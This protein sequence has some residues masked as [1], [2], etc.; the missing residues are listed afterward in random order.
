MVRKFELIPLCG[1]RF[2]SDSFRI[3]RIT[4]KNN[5]KKNM[6]FALALL[7]SAVSNLPFVRSSNVCLLTYLLADNDLE[8]WIR[9]DLE[10]LVSSELIQTPSLTSWIYFDH[11]N[12]GTNEDI[13]D[14]LPFVYNKDGS[15]RTGEKPEGSFYF[16]QD[17][18]LGKLVIEEDLGE[19]NSDSPETVKNFVNTALADCI[20]RGSEEYMIVFGSH[21]GGIV[22]FGGDE[23][24]RRRQ[25]ELLQTNAQITG[26][27]RSSLDA[28]LGPGSKFDVVGFDACLMQA[29]GT[30]DDYKS[31]TKYLLASEDLEPGHGWWYQDVPQSAGG[32]ALDIAK[33]LQSS[34]LSSL[35]G[36]SQHEIPKTLSIVDLEE[37]ES[38][39]LVKWENLSR[40]W[41]NLM[42]AND[43]EVVIMLS[44]ARTT[45]Y[46]FDGAIEY[47]KKPS[48]DIYNF[49]EKFKT[50]C[51]AGANTV[52]GNALEEAMA[53]YKDMFVVKGNGPGT[54]SGL[55]GMHVLFPSKKGYTKNPEYFDNLLYFDPSTATKTA[56]QWLNFL[57]TFYSTGT[58]KGG[59]SVCQTSST[60]E[61]AT[62]DPNALL[63]NPTVSDFR[64]GFHDIDMEAARSVTSILIEYGTDF[65]PLLTGLSA[66]RRLSAMRK[67]DN[68]STT[69]E[70]SRAMSN[71]RYTRP[72]RR[73][74][75][76]LRERR[77]LD[78]QITSSST[79]SPSEQ[80]TATIELSEQG[81]ATIE[82][83]GD[84]SGDG[85]FDDF[86]YVFSGDLLGEYENSK[87][88]AS[89]DRSFW[90][91]QDANQNDE[92]VYVY[93]MGEGSKEAE[94][95]YFPPSSNGV[96][97]N[98]LVELWSIDDAIDMGGQYG[99]LAF[100]T[101]NVNNNGLVTT[102]SL[103]TNSGNG[104]SYSE[105]PLS[106][107]GQVVPI[108]ECY[109]ELSGFEINEWIGGFSQTVLDWD[110][111][112]P[113]GMSKVDA[114][115]YA[116]TFDVD[117]YSIEIFGLDE[118]TGAYSF[119]FYEFGQDG[120]P[121]FA[122]QENIEGT[123]STV[124]Q[125]DR[126]GMIDFDYGETSTSDS[127]ERVA[128]VGVFLAM[129]IFCFI[130]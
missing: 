55:T 25:R 73:H 6:R 65:T 22:G 26:A 104:R 30:A 103:Y 42:Q 19:L 41:T 63:I 49:M 90:T 1:F 83:S 127:S 81:T 10:E 85:T 94:V 57:N 78:D 97:S 129:S 5:N 36:D 9:I 126:G 21:G 39:F 101:N 130:W 111:N 45:A 92:L 3:Y 115:V 52:L 24:N 51:P 121:V 4:T 109:G 17:H 96:T 93:D 113:I 50:L 100:S 123:R 64:N 48:V 110:P 102:I 124:G 98:D 67:Q 7:L 16:R 108:V 95:I 11:R 14:R 54:P 23:N 91:I 75:E 79:F 18:D 87:Y 107:G 59:P 119:I 70:G 66:R 72:S 86:L 117:Y 37:F 15:E 2:I 43:S 53:A 46:A 76:L 118:N 44:R 89:W 20:S 12:F 32:S 29:L 47:D 122:I 112:N 106:A 33:S 27:L 62:D 80:G 71:S 114:A 58:P 82:P 116:D 128:T 8:Y 120:V 60:P 56:P 31:V 74:M 99:F 125:I 105:V 77:R 38:S 13:N 84:A 28:N 61:E 34:F 88:F 40:E 68:K 35:H 69:E